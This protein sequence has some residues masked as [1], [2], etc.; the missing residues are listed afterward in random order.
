[1]SDYQIDRLSLSFLWTRTQFNF[2]QG[3]LVEQYPYGFLA[4]PSLF[5]E[6]FNDLREF[7]EDENDLGLPWR[8]K[9]AS[10]FW[11]HYFTGKAPLGCH[12]KCRTKKSDPLA[13]KDPGQSRRQLA[14]QGKCR[15]FGKALSTG[16]A[17]LP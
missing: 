11:R 7:G 15:F 13:E 8:R 9:R 1:M 16:M 4:R 2:F 3:A 12:W 14:A 17:W 10:R 6:K 5:K